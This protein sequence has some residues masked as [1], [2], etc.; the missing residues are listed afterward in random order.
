MPGRGNSQGTKNVYLPLAR[1]HVTKGA[2]WGHVAGTDYWLNMN[3]GFDIF[4]AASTATGDE[5]SSR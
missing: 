3:S 2:E 4:G 5:H 1:K